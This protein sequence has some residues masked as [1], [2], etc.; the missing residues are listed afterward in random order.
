MF[1]FINN[2]T[3]YPHI[4]DIGDIVSIHIKIKDKLKLRFQIFN[5]ICIARKGTG[6][7]RTITIRRVDFKGRVEK[8]FPIFSPC[9]QKIIIKNKSKI[10]RAKLYYLR[11]LFGKQA[12][13]KKIYNT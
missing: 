9:I 7:T 8:I 4:V 3:K 5:G 10:R 11:S 12:K 2:I 1:N 6:I 13:T